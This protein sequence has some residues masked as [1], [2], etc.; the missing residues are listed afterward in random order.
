MLTQET[1]IDGP[2]MDLWSILVKHRSWLEN[3]NQSM[4]AGP[5]GVDPPTDRRF[6]RGPCLDQL[7]RL[8]STAPPTV[9]RSTHRPWLVLVDGTCNF[10]TTVICLVSNPGCYI[11]S[12]LGSFVLE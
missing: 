5:W 8:L 6:H 12:P 4:K 2:S 10:P 1:S 9:H 11:I 7:L 3:F